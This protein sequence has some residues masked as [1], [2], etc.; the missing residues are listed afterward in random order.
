[1]SHLALYYGNFRTE[2]DNNLICGI[3]E[4]VASRRDENSTI[5]KFVI[6]EAVTSTP[7]YIQWFEHFFVSTVAP[8]DWDGV[9]LHG[10]LA[11][12]EHGVFY[13][14]GED[15]EIHL[16]PTTTT[17][18]QRVTVD[19][20]NY[21]VYSV[22][23]YNW[24]E[25]LKWWRISNVVSFKPTG[26]SNKE[27]ARPKRYTGYPA[28]T[29]NFDI[30]STVIDTNYTY[31]NEYREVEFWDDEHE[32]SRLLFFRP[33]VD[34]YINSGGGGTEDNIVMDIDLYYK[35]RMYDFH[36]DNLRNIPDGV[37]ES[38]F[39]V[40][41]G[42]TSRLSYQGMKIGEISYN[43]KKAKFSF[44]TLVSALTD[45]EF[46][47][48]QEMGYFYV[49]AILVYTVG[50]DRTVVSPWY[51]FK[52]Y[53]NGTVEQGSEIEGMDILPDTN[54]EE[55]DSYINGTGES[56]LEVEGQELSVD[57]LLMTSYVVT[58]NELE[59]FGD[60][61]WSNE[62]VQGLYG[63][64]TA[65]I[66]NVL[67]CKRIPFEVET[68]S[69]QEEI[70]LGNMPTG[71]SAYKS[72]SL[73]K[74]VIG[75][76]V[77][78]TN[79]IKPNSVYGNNTPLYFSPTTTVSI[80]LPYIGI[81]TL[82]TN[83]LYYYDNGTIKGRKISVEYYY[84]IIY[85]SC[86]ACVYVHNVSGDSDD[87]RVLIGSYNGNCGIDIPITASNRASNELS[88]LKMGSNNTATMWGRLLSGNILGAASGQ[89]QGAIEQRF[90]QNNAEVHFT[91]A[92]GISSQVASYLPANVR[93]IIE[94][95]NYTEPSTYAHDFGKPCNLSLNLN[96]LSGY[97][98]ISHTVDLSG[99]PCL[100][101]EKELLLDLLTSGF[102]LRQE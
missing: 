23:L 58:E 34:E 1:M 3:A 33:Y 11:S 95:P 77:M 60:V 40:Y 62:M 54:Y 90:E 88:L 45:S 2:D 44:S 93:V 48:Y 61:L 91:T 85:G 98:Q 32:P 67:S 86:I 17:R 70:I 82:P 87:N 36:W 49:N 81:N 27:V 69:N 59:A 22:N 4:D 73:H 31:Q 7:S 46:E 72:A 57:N 55:N 18:W 10:T 76:L 24:A 101:E 26:E 89:V 52:F 20:V 102:Y 92:G 12:D 56:D 47:E 80:Y 28:T 100:K 97:T 84:D 74:Q 6:R 9:S 5:Y 75:S 63:V 83:S 94:V 29:Q 66:E 38:N 64:Q 71:V 68:E 35:D 53:A 65:P 15:D 14:D 25:A 37:S 41:F 50:D 96:E 8:T 21:F 16:I 19:N 99:F 51:T 79:I 43:T 39:S 30:V 13:W 78:P 42:A